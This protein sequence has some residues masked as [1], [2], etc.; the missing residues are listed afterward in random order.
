MKPIL[1]LLLLAVG[2]A[3][4]QPPDRRASA[5][6]EERDVSPAALVGTWR[7]HSATPRQRGTAL[8]TGVQVYNL[9]FTRS[10]FQLRSDGALWVDYH[11]AYVAKLDL[12]GGLQEPGKLWQEVGEYRLTTRIGHSYLFIDTTPNDSGRVQL[13]GDTLLFYEEPHQ[14]LVRLTRIR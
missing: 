6:T 7:L 3:R 12:F 9:L 13:H 11:P 10:R 4:C 1:P 2:L 8:D 5:G 14:A